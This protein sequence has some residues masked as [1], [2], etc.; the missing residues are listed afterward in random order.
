MIT[1]I[2]QDRRQGNGDGG[3]INDVERSGQADQEQEEPF[4]LA[5]SLVP[6]Q[7]LVWM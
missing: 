1:N 7:L 2:S 3:H 4:D 6:G 5:Q